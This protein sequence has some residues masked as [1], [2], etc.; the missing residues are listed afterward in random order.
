MIPGHPYAGGRLGTKQD[1]LDFAAYID[2]LNVEVKKF[3]AEG[4]CTD[5]AMKEV[6][7]PKYEK[8]TNYANF[9][10]M[11]VERMCYLANGN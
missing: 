4:K 8:W 9:L 7:L 3:A 6:K 11:N 5:T 1:V 10:P 2:D